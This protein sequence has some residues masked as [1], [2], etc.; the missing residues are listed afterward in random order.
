M[1]ILVIFFFIGQALKDL[2]KVPRPSSPPVARL[3]TKWLLEYGLPS[4]HAAVGLAMPGTVFIFSAS[5]YQIDYV[6]CAV[7]V[8]LW[9]LAVSAS[10]VYLGMHSVLDVVCGILLVLI[11]FALLVP[12]MDTLDHALLTHPSSPLVVFGLSVAMVAA[13]PASASW[14]PAR[15]AHFIS[16]QGLLYHRTCKK[17][18]LCSWPLLNSYLK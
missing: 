12:F 16:C 1:Y 10:R 9:C 2:L 4:T 8:G 5:R 17:D 3:D 13:Y 18:F 11:L 7:L 6:S 14:N 15:Y